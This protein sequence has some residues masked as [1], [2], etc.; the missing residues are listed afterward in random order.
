MNAVWLR[1]VLINK[2]S[3]LRDGSALTVIKVKLDILPLVFDI[4]EVV[5]VF[6]S[7]FCFDSTDL[8]IDVEAAT[9]FRVRHTLE[10]KVDLLIQKSTWNRAEKNAQ[11]LIRQVIHT[12]LANESLHLHGYGVSPLGHSSKLLDSVGTHPALWCLD[13]PIATLDSDIRI[14]S[15]LSNG[16]I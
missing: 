1:F 14:F 13:F 7:A 11:L 10:E 5:Q 3:V 2:V 6:E 12:I 15:Q 9:V 8:Q 4:V 16:F